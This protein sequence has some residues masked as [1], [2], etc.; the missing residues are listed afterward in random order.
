MTLHSPRKQEIAAIVASDSTDSE[1][2]HEL[3]SY[4]TSEER[5]SIDMMLSFVP[6][7]MTAERMSIVVDELL[8]HRCSKQ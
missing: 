6:V 8:A 1:K 3:F 5:D 2:I 7:E 4:L